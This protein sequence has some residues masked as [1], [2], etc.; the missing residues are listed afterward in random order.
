MEPENYLRVGLGVTRKRKNTAKVKVMGF[1]VR[2]TWIGILI[3]YCYLKPPNLNFFI[4][5]TEIIVMPP[6]RAISTNDTKY[7]EHVVPG[8][9]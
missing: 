9:Q 8:P 1:G 2:Q 6:H 4:C 3:F 5:K 7:I